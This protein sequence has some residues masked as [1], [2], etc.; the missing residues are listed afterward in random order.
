MSLLEI[1]DL[2][3]SYGTGNVL[4]GV[5]LS[6]EQGELVGVVG[7]NGHGKTTLLRAISGLM[8]RS[9]GSVTLNGQALKGVAPEK[10]AQAGL[11]HVP[12]GDLVYKGMTILENLLVGGYANRSEARSQ[13]QL[14]RVYDLF[15]KLKERSDQIASSL[16]GGERRMLGIGRGLMMSNCKILM[17]DEPS[18]GLAPVVIDQIYEAIDGLRANGMTI[19]VVEENIARVADHANRLHLMDGGHF[20]WSGS[21]SEMNENKK[22]IDTY[23]G[24]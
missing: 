15:P 10:I 6:V 20:V 4:N 23:L 12:Q 19:V 17:L 2:V 22:I 5:D 13:E 7:P 8:P 21:P 11:V 18:L 1:K 24:A 9:K 3:A 16:S 14:E